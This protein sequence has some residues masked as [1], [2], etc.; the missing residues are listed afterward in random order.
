MVGKNKPIYGKELNILGDGYC[1]KEGETTPTSSGGAYLLF[2]DIMLT[3][4]ELDAPRKCLFLNK[5]K[6]KI[7]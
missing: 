6:N 4:N 7:I 3:K 2:E 1:G 5:D